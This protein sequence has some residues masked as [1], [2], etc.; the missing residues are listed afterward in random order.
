M[1]REWFEAYRIY[2]EDWPVYLPDLNPIEPVWYWLKVKLFALFPE[3]ISIRRSES[4]WLYFK[5]C[6]VKA[7]DALD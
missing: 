3:L 5:Q 6:I 4:D 1:I 2:V 7:W